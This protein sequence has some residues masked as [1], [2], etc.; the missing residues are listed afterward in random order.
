[1]QMQETVNANTWWRPDVGVG[2]VDQ[3]RARVRIRARMRARTRA[4]M[5][6]RMRERTR[7]RMGVPITYL[8]SIPWH[9][10]T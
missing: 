3:H 8:T 7:T 6:A 1:M 4:R 10:Q 2:V 9:G 5:R